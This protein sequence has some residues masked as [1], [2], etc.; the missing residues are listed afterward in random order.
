MNSELFATLESDV[1][2]HKTRESEVLN[3]YMNWHNHEGSQALADV[4]TAEAIQ[5]RGVE[6]VY[7]IRES[8]NLD[9]VFGEDPTSKF[10]E[11][12][13][14][15]MW[16]RSFDSYE[17]QRDFFD[18]MGYQVNDEMTV[19][20]NPKSFEHQV[21]IRKPREGDLLYF[22]MDNSLFELNWVEPDIPFLQTGTKNILT[23]TAQK[24]VYSGEEINPT[25]GV[26]ED[27]FGVEDQETLDNLKN[28]DGLSDVLKNQYQEVE[29]IKDESEPFIEDKEPVNGKGSPFAPL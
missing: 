13:K 19:Q 1:G 21:G 15:S 3:P 24:F 20:V 16:I 17:G 23:L 11:C 7:I 5:A 6:G 8:E 2:Y 14:I 26:N 18:K 9:L 29:Q 25:K 28:L 12:K 22:P 10:K 27:P 4:L